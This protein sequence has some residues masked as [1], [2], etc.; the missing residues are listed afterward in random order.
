[1]SAM[2]DEQLMSKVQQGDGRAMH[3]LFKRHHGPLFGFI[4][5]RLAAQDASEDLAQEVFIRVWRYRDTYEADRAFLPWLYRIA[6]NLLSDWSG[7]RTRNPVGEETGSGRLLPDERLE[8]NDRAEKVRSAVLQ[9]PPAQCEVLL[10][11]RWSGMTYREIGDMVGCSEGAVKVRV[12]RALETLRSTLAP[13]RED[14]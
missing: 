2:T 6:R 12:F 11:S 13:L 4:F 9:L 10:L 3:E 5:G 1:M 7:S 14:F 8:V